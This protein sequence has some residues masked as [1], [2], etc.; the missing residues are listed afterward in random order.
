MA[1]D[2]TPR[3]PRRPELAR[4]VNA[5]ILTLIHRIGAHVWLDQNRQVG[6]F[7]ECG[8]MG[9]A[10]TTLAEYEAGGGAWIE[11]HEGRF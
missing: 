9:V 8:C 5:H 7:C 3:V 2:S 4:E 10:P 6:F 1:E 11:G